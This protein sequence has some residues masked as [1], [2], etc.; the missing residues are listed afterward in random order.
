M[1]Y[2]HNKSCREDI[3]TTILG[4]SLQYCKESSKKFLDRMESSEEII[5][6]HLHKRYPDG[7]C[8]I[9]PDIVIET[10]STVYI[11]ESKLKYE[12]DALN[13]VED[14]VRRLSS[15]EE[16]YYKNKIPLLIIPDRKNLNE[17]I[18]HCEDNYCFDMD[19]Q[20]DRKGKLLKRI[21]NDYNSLSDKIT[22]GF[23]DIEHIVNGSPYDA[24]LREMMK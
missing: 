19:K 9:C 14:Y 17:W 22:M 6:I 5:N 23:I 24:I 7:D 18:Y 10:E 3:L 16:F 1:I 11:G 13:Q 12:P 2:I 8:K 4:M 20:T 21:G 15:L